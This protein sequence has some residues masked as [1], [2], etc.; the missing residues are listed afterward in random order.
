MQ[1]KIKNPYESPIK[2]NPTKD[3][4]NLISLAI[5]FEQGVKA[6]S[7]RKF[8]EEMPEQFQRIIAIQHHNSKSL[9]FNSGSMVNGVY[10]DIYNTYAF[11]HW[12][13]FPELD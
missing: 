13:P 2:A 11:T 4:P 9:I 10:H 3:A 8:S 5:A 1:A 7:P 12:L 6:N